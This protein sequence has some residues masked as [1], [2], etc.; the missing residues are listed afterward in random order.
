MT[1][2]DLHEMFLNDEGIPYEWCVYGE[3][4]ENDQ[5]HCIAPNG[6]GW[7]VYYSERGQKREVKEFENESEACKELYGRMLDKKKLY[8]DLRREGKMK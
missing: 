1:R 3:R 4:F 6:E 5:K 7:K 2:V 8:E